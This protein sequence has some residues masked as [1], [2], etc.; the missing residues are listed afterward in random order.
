MN[1]GRGLG[2]LWYILAALEALSKVRG[3]LDGIAYSRRNTRPGYPPVCIWRVICLKFLLNEPYTLSIVE[4]LKSS[5][6][7]RQLCGLGDGVPSER[8]IGRFH[9]LLV[10]KYPELSQKF[11]LGMARRLSR[12]MPSDF[13][14]IVAVDSSDIPSFSCGNLP[15]PIDTGSMWGVRTR[16]RRRKAVG[17][18]KV[19]DVFGRK[20]HA[21]VCAKYGVPIS[22]IITHSKVTDNTVVAQLIERARDVY[23]DSFQPEILLADRGYDDKKLFAYLVEQDIEPIILIRRPTADDGLYQGL[24]DKKGRPLCGDSQTPMQYVRSEG[25]SHLFTCPDDGCSLR[26]KSSGMIRHC[27]SSEGV[28]FDG[29]ERSPESIRAFGWRIRRASPEWA[30]LY[31]RRQVVERFF[32]S[33]KQSRL[34]TKCRFLDSRKIEL[35]LNLSILTYLATQVAHVAAGNLKDIRKMRIKF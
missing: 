25:A 24:F 28:W 22:F 32:A 7:L 9:S 21:M 13:G 31:G 29:S 14:K 16:K 15:E 3:M 10:T 19:E 30:E 5:P 4:R 26:G 6:E 8:T 34:L 17:G 12:Y 20:I 18:K 11:I 27:D 1:A 23:G 35:H 33:V 2:F